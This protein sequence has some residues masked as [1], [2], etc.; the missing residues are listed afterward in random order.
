MWPKPAQA[1]PGRG[2]G[3]EGPGRE[4]RPGAGGAGGADG[5]GD[6]GGLGS[7]LML[8][9]QPLSRIYVPPDRRHRSSSWIS[10]RAV[11]SMEAQE[12]AN[13]MAKSRTK[14]TDSF[15]V[16]LITLS[17]K[18]DKIKVNQQGPTL[19]SGFGARMGMGYNGESLG[20]DPGA[21]HRIG[22]V[23][24]LKVICYVRHV[25]FHCTNVRILAIIVRNVN[26]KVRL[27]LIFVYLTDCY[28]F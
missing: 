26:A 15:L 25:R 27:T 24:W 23:I 6:T 28:G 22:H 9:M 3:S 5:W 21:R 4:G 12:T 8:G 10:Q 7:D 1:W 16:N 13:F 20:N 19:G 18:K 17:I 2:R 11:A 14:P